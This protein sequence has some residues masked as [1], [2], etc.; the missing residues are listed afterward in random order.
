MAS[1]TLSFVQCDNQ[2]CKGIPDEVPSGPFT[3]VLRFHYL[4]S[5]QIFLMNFQNTYRFNLQ[6][7]Y[8]KSIKKHPLP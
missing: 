1:F 6:N 2:N 4:Y 7:T 3:L 5:E 8:L